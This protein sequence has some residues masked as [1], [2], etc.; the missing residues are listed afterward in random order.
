MLRYSSPIYLYTCMCMCA[1]ARA[2]EKELPM[3]GYSTMRR[4]IM[5]V[6]CCFNGD[7]CRV[8]RAAFPGRAIVSPPHHLSKK[9]L[10]CS[11]ELFFC[12]SFPLVAITYSSVAPFSLFFIPLVTSLKF[13][14][15]RFCPVKAHA[16]TSSH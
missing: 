11:A 1:S 13:P 3:Q 14:C 10:H 9:A 2:R 4:I 6:A 7:V 5:R 15:V 8:A 12:V 16:R